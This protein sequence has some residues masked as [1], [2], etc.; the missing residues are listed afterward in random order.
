MGYKLLVIERGEA[1]GQL[2]SHGGHAV[3][4]VGGPLHLAAHVAAPHAAGQALQLHPL[5][6]VAHGHGQVAQG[7]G[8][9]QQAL[10]AQVHVQQQARR[11]QLAAQR[12]GQLG[13]VA[14]GPGGLGETS[15]GKPRTVG[16]GHGPHQ[17][18]QLGHAQ[19]INRKLPTDAG[20]GVQ[21]G[22]IIE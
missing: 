10:A 5:A 9:Q 13:L 21:P 18:A 8:G 17:A 7:I 20:R 19:L 4:G 15:R 6:V 12:S 1:H 3:V 2:V 14:G 22:E 11:N 16:T